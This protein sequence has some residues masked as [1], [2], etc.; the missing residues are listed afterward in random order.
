MLSPLI[1]WSALLYAGLHV[2]FPEYSHSFVSSKFD[3]RS[4]KLVSHALLALVRQLQGAHFGSFMCSTAACFRSSLRFCT[5]RLE[6]V[7]LSCVG[8]CIL[9]LWRSL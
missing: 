1:L 2:V 7:T 5:P 4:A 3:E 6:K 9:A 8:H